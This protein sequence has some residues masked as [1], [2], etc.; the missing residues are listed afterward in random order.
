M[1]FVALAILPALAVADH[2]PAYGYAPAPVYCRETNTSVYAEVKFVKM[3]SFC[4]S[5]N[6]NTNIPF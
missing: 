6:S 2:A 1:F 5:L 4:Q 3:Y